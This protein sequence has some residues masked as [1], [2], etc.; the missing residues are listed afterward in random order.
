MN[1][2][3]VR[4]NR[5]VRNPV[6]IVCLGDPPVLVID[7]STVYDNLSTDID[8]GLGVVPWSSS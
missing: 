7:A 8:E 3:F 6:D 5:S 1:I 2:L 4:D